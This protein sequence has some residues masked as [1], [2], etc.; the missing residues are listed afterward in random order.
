[1]KVTRHHDQLSQKQF[2]HGKIFEEKPIEIA[3]IATA[4][5]VGLMQPRKSGR[6]FGFSVPTFTAVFLHRGSRRH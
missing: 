2:P 4:V 1:M 6:L 3:M 5:I